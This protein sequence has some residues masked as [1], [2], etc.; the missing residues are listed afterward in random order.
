[1]AARP[2]RQSLNRIIKRFLYLARR[3]QGVWHVPGGLTDPKIKVCHPA[4]GGG[5]TAW[6][7]KGT[8]P[9]RRSEVEPQ[10]KAVLREQPS[11]APKKNENK[12]W[13]NVCD[14]ARVVGVNLPPVQPSKD[15]CVA[16]LMELPSS[17]TREEVQIAGTLFQSR[18]TLPATFSEA[19]TFHKYRESLSARPRKL[20]DSAK[21]AIQLA[22]DLLPRDWDK[23]AQRYAEQCV[24]SLSSN[25]EKKEPRHM[26]GEGFGPEEM[27]A[28][29]AGKHK[30]KIGRERRIR[31]LNDS[32][33]ARVVT[34]APYESA[35][36]KPLHDSLYDALCASG[37]VLRGPPTDEKMRKFKPREGE[38]MVSGDYE[39]A[40]DNMSSAV[41]RHCLE[42]LRSRS[43]YVPNS[44]WDAA[45]SFFGPAIMSFRDQRF[46]QMTGQLM[47]N[48]L[49]FPLLCLANLAGVIE[50]LGI[51]K[52][53][54][55]IAA[56]RLLINGDDIAF[57]ATRAEV[58][59]WMVACESLSLKVSRSKTLVHERVVTINS[60]FFLDGSLVWILRSKSFSL[61]EKADKK[62]TALARRDRWCNQIVSVIRE[63]WRGL[64]LAQRILF[65]RLA[66]RL[67]SPL[68]R[69]CPLNLDLPGPVY[70]DGPW[71]QLWLEKNKY[72][73]KTPSAPM[74]FWRLPA[75]YESTAEQPS[76]K[77]GWFV[78]RL[79]T[80]ATQWGRTRSGKEEEVTRLSELHRGARS[81][82]SAVFGMPIRELPST[83]SRV[84]VS[85]HYGDG[86]GLGAASEKKLY[87]REVTQ[88]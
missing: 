23:S 60:H 58:E 85:C 55:L 56:G 77:M 81:I 18:K 59:R 78:H 76:T 4:P 19:V 50:G 30:I 40:T 52:T 70:L 25:Y 54:K 6:V 38:V 16:A 88:D 83:S 39:A 69:D 27:R 45:L 61:E 37:A 47:G 11:T 33:K 66:F 64:N 53:R 51:K 7:P 71:K 10:K 44:V 48:F 68:C 3:Y 73:I 29:Y 79:C 80:Q 14:L 57:M 67:F 20:S 49:S 12:K 22:V 65:S 21:E 46:V 36:L 84:G 2:T 35:Y 17:P 24:P 42:V 1:V 31:I 62:E 5:G 86:R 15:T 63:H 28:F 34:I 74:L 43:R 87:Y 72:K 8:R 9:G 32:G 82:C 41:T 13:K 26:W 75:D